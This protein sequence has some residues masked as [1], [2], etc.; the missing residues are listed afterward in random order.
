MTLNA[1]NHGVPVTPVTVNTICPINYSDNAKQIALDWTI[2]IHNPDAL[3]SLLTQ[4]LRPI[5]GSGITHVF[6]TRADFSHGLES[7]LNW[8]SSCNLDWISGKRYE[9]GDDPDEIKS[10]FCTV[11]GD[12]N[13]LLTFLG[14]EEC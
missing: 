11:V 9:I 8:L 14:L 3:E 2:S 13:V 12:K 7:Q 1:E 10:K 6:C 5:G 4:N